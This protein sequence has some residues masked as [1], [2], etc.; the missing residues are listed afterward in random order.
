LQVAS[1]GYLVTLQNFTSLLTNQ[2]MNWHFIQQD[3]QQGP[4][5]D[6]QIKSLIA[7]GNLSADDLAWCEGMAEWKPIREITE[8]SV[9]PVKAA[10]PESIAKPVAES[11]AEPATKP[12][13]ASV[14]KTHVQTYLWQ[15]IVTTIFCCL[16]LGVVA[17][18]YAAQVDSLAR[19]GDHAAAVAASISAKK[20]CHASFLAGVLFVVIYVVSGVTFSVG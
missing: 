1:S 5:T 4:V 7:S 12:A 16:P 14:M 11:I 2:S 20:W 15:S 8:L 10:A 17:I 13:A 19:S 18:V 3:E 9:Y 6:E